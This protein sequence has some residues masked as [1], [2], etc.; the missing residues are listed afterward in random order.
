M[1]WS[2]EYTRKYMQDYAEA[3][4]NTSKWKASARERQRKRRHKLKLELVAAL[5]G[6]CVRC[7][8]SEHMF[9][10]EFDHRDPSTKQHEPSYLIS[11]SSRQTAFEYITKNCELLCANCHALKTVAYGDNLKGTNTSDT[12]S[13]KVLYESVQP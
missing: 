9:A 13:E 4:R 1:T 10:L 5:G 8:F 3:H 2:K 7:N 12:T 11:S 6:K